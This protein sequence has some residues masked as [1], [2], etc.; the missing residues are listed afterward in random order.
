M[1]MMWPTLL[2]LKIRE[3]I[4]NSA[5]E[6]NII[7]IYFAKCSLLIKY[8]PLMHTQKSDTTAS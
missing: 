7:G 6:C 3:A 5:V 4:S 2:L 8:Q 1:M